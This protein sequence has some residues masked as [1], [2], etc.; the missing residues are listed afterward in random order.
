M[1]GSRCRIMQ[2]PGLNFIFLIIKLVSPFHSNLSLKLLF[3]SYKNTAQLNTPVV[4]IVWQTWSNPFSMNL[5]HRPHSI[6]WISFI[7]CM[8][9][10][11]ILMLRSWYNWLICRFYIQMVFQVFQYTCNEHSSLH[12]PFLNLEQLYLCLWFDCH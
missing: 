10:S 4:W 6:L 11:I 2:S 7:V 5:F 12:L 8:I 3:S 9:I 1:Y